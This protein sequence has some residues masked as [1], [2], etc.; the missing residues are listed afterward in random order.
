MNHACILPTSPKPQNHARATT[1]EGAVISELRTNGD[2]L[3]GVFDKIIDAMCSITNETETALSKGGALR[4]AVRAADASQV[5]HYF[6]RLDA[7]EC[8]DVHR[9]LFDA[10]VETKNAVRGH[11][12]IVIREWG[13]L[14]A[15]RFEQDNRHLLLR[16][17][18][19]LAKKMGAMMQAVETKVETNTNQITELHEII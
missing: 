11:E 18:A 5:M 2:V 19:G 7:G 9:R 4:P 12:D 1:Q 10:L 6:A 15:K 17:N 3:N 8:R 14:L 16:E 13:K